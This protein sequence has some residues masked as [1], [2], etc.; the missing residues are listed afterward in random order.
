M[1]DNKIID[2]HISEIIKKQLP[3]APAD[4]WFVKKTMNRLP[5]KRKRMRSTAEIISYALSVVIIIAG[6]V[7]QLTGIYISKTI[8]M[9]NILISA[10]LFFSAIL[11]TLSIS[12]PIL[13]EE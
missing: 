5:E 6:W 4:Q 9:E 12:I 10:S 11:I 7:W 2:H 8:T 13:K 3:D 1:K